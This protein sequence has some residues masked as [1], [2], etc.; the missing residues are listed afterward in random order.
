[1]AKPFLHKTVL[2]KIRLSLIKNN[3]TG[4][5]NLTQVP[6]SFIKKTG[7]FL[8]NASHWWPDELSKGPLT[9]GILSQELNAIFVMLKLQ[10]EH[11]S[12]KSSDISATFHYSDAIATI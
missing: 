2:M 7:D 11:P 5:I 9:H 8:N 4:G 1:M 3:I 10:F 12:G 6:F